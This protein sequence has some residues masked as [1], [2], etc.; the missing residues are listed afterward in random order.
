M[1]PTNDYTEDRSSRPTRFNRNRFKFKLKLI[2]LFYRE[3]VL[4]ADKKNLR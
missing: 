2:N 1:F 3:T 4:K